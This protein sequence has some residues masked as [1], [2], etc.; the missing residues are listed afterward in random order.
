[1]GVHRTEGA[2]SR[3]I[4]D[5]WRYNQSDERSCRL[6]LL[7]NPAPLPCQACPAS[8]PLRHESSRLSG[9]RL[10]IGRMLTIDGPDAPPSDRKKLNLGGDGWMIQCAGHP[11][12]PT[13]F[14]QGRMNPAGALRRGVTAALLMPSKAA[15]SSGALS[16]ADRQMGR[17]KSILSLRLAGTYVSDAVTKSSQSCVTCVIYAP[18][19]TRIACMVGGE[20]KAFACQ[21]RGDEC[22]IISL[23]PMFAQV[24]CLAKE[25]SRF[26]R[27]NSITQ[28]PQ[29]KPSSA[30]PPS[31]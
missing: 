3:R 13:C 16:H 15:R 21:S 25:P 26:F 22:L 5:A 6:P 8:P 9:L 12:K 31:R 20:R 18:G 24:Q 2:T 17:T 11:L 28:S 7:A 29:K 14:T 30:G 23:R 1:M 10:V 27:A 19:K 4:E